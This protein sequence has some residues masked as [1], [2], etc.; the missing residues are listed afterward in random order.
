MSEQTTSVDATIVPATAAP[1]L[2]ATLQQKRTALS[3]ISVFGGA[4]NW[5]L[6]FHVGGFA[7]LLC[8]PLLWRFLPESRQLRAERA[9]PAAAGERLFTNLGCVTCHNPD[10]KGRGP[11]LEGL[12]GSRVALAGGDSV[13]ADETYLR[14][15]IVD[16]AARLVIGYEPLMPTFQ[17]L[18]GEEGLM[19]LIEYIKTL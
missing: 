12:Y 1:T 10:S 18:V 15:S 3:L 2:E 9:A 16:P 7:P 8:V 5:Q 4:E 19:H 11:S 6:V 14:E 13:V 17:G